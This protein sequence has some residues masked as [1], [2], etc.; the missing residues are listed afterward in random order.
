MSENETLTALG[1]KLA[2]EAEAAW[3][4]DAEHFNRG[5]YATA[6]VF[7]PRLV[8]DLLDVV[9]DER[10]ARE[11]AEA[12]TEG[13][14]FALT[15]EHDMRLAAEARADA[16]AAKVARVEALAA[17]LEALVGDEAI[18]P[19]YQQVAHSAALSIRAALADKEA[20]RD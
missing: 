17:Q 3:R 7:T 18:D 10:T 20:D 2:H 16:L 8:L 9:R 1:P 12:S 11:E 19:D 4:K 13:V 14:R 6:P 15:N 5:P